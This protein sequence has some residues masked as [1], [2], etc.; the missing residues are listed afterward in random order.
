MVWA[1]IDDA[2]L[3]NPKVAKAGVIGLAMHVAGIT[4]SCRNLT[5]G[6]VPSSVARRLVD[7]SEL[8]TEVLRYTDTIPSVASSLSDV[9]RDIPPMMGDA[10]AEDLVDIGLWEKVNG[11]YQI[12]DF[13]D[14]NPSRAQVE[15]ERIKKANAGAK[16]A[17]KRWQKAGN[18]VAGAMAGPLAG[19]MANDAPVPD[20]VP[21][22]SP[23]S[24]GSSPPSQSSQDLHSGVRRAANATADGAFGLTVDSWAGGIRSVSGQPYPRPSGKAAGRLAEALKA[25]RGADYMG[26]P[27]EHAHEAGAAYAR[28]NPGRTLDVFDYERWVG[29]GRPD[30]SEAGRKPTLA[31]APRDSARAAEHDAILRDV[32][33]KA[34]ASGARS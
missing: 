27:C 6:F 11:G 9:A 30:R 1:R 28:A 20:P 25:E 32:E 8:A 17:Q 29:S 5:D 2:I 3:D 33:E 34:R 7:V 15:A 19:S 10:V 24:L 14:Y 22:V 23:S 4:Y 31:F 26:D 12:H 21:L 18:S 16:G 13:L